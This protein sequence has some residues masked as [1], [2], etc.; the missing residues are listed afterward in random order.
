MRAFITFHKGLLK[1]P[2]R[3]RLWLM[4]LVVFNLVVPLFFLDRLEAQVVLAALLASML[5][6]T[7]LTGLTGFTRLL[8]LGHILWVPMLWFLWGRLGQI[9]ADDAFGLW[10]RVLM[11]LNAIS[12]VVDGVDV[13]R[14]IAGDRK[15]TVEG[16]S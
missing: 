16:L 3:V 5:L 11:I 1:S 10:L 9:P 14:Y 8:G 4:L 7:V 2:I 12:L 6:M 13:I 15:A